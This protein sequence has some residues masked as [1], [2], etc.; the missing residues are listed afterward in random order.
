M[1]KFNISS[2]TAKHIV[3]A[4]YA[5]KNAMQG[6]LI[7]LVIVL[8]VSCSRSWTMKA[9]DAGLDAGAEAWKKSIE[10]KKKKETV[11]MDK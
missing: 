1:N 9:V 5:L 11:I 3:S 2:F 6:I 4:M 8:F 10:E 7:A